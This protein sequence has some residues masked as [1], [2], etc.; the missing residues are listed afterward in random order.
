MNLAFTSKLNALFF[1]LK[2]QKKNAAIEI[3]E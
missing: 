3:R 1:F 2:T